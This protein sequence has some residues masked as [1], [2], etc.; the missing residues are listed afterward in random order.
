VEKR[1]SAVESEIKK[2]LNSDKRLQDPSE[3][4]HSTV[5]PKAIGA[6]VVR[7]P[8]FTGLHFNFSFLIFNLF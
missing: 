2:A 8:A 4:S 6:Q 7:H 5:A 1:L 3:C